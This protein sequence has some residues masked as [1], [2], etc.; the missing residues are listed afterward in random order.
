MVVNSQ[1]IREQI[2]RLLPM[3]QQKKLV[4]SYKCASRLVIRTGRGQ[5]GGFLGSLLA[6]I[7][8]PLIANAVGKLFGGCH[9][10]NHGEDED[11]DDRLRM[12]KSLSPLTDQGEL[13][14]SQS[15]NCLVIRSQQTKSGGTVI[16]ALRCL[17]SSNK[18]KDHAFF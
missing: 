2:E 7:G 12:F 10:E 11:A 4:E 5:K 17:L 6:G 3:S 13:D 14:V 16:P 15:E 18:K 8:I 1:E 9:G